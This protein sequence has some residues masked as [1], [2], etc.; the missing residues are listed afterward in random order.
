MSFKQLLRIVDGTET[1]QQPVR[2]DRS[3]DDGQQRQASSKPL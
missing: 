2:G 3:T 1:I